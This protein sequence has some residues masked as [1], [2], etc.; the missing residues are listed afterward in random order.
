M[1]D[2]TVV[3]I[4]GANQGLGYEIVRILSSSPSNYHVLLGSRSVERGSEAI[5]KLEAEGLKGSISLMQLDVKDDSSI[6]KAAEEVEE[7]FGRLDVLINN[8][9]ITVNPAVP[10]REN[11]R[12]VFETNVFGSAETTEAFTSLLLRSQAPR[13]LFISS[14]LGSLGGAMD[15]TCHCYGDPYPEYRASKAALNM[16]MIWYHR[17][18]GQKGVKVFAIC[19]GLLATKM[20]D[21]F[22][23][24]HLRSL[25]GVDAVVGAEWVCSVVEGQRDAD[26]GKFIH[27][28]GVNPW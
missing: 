3:L 22:G 14:T 16:F 13:L 4:T 19:P 28:N 21:Q 15:P 7:K 5:S 26:V 23:P 6:A 11:L 10:M 24:D 12:E 27:K 17:T 9:A 1:S 18:L 2:R 20:M 8:A 25:G